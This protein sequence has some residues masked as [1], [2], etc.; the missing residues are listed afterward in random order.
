MEIMPRYR[1]RQTYN[2]KHY[3]EYVDAPSAEYITKTLFKDKKY[4][5]RLTEFFGIKKF[6]TNIETEIDPETELN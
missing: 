4:F 6:P 5:K 3:D 1:V 2:G